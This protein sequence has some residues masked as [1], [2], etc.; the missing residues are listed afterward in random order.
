MNTFIRSLADNCRNDVAT[1]CFV[2]LT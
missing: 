1:V 2:T